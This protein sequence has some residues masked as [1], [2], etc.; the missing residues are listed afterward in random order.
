[1]AASAAYLLH[2]RLP[3]IQLLQSQSTPLH[4]AIANEPVMLSLDYRATGK[5][6][7]TQAQFK[8]QY[9]EQYKK[10]RDREI[11]LASTLVGPHKDDMT[12]AI[13]GQEA[14]YYASEGQQRSCATALRLAEWHLLHACSEE[15]PLMLIDDIGASMDSERCRR[16]FLQI[17]QLSQVFISSTQAIPEELCVREHK[18]ITPENF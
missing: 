8:Q 9:M 18:T 1:M 6:E 16:L 2:K 12:I 13:G 3:L 7:G 5:I 11:I 17:N 10:N 14:R 4:Q 15:K